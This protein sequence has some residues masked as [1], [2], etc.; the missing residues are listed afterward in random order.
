MSIMEANKM[1]R[2]RCFACSF[3]LLLTP[4]LALAGSI[5]F[6]PGSLIQSPG[7]IF[8]AGV[9]IANP[10]PNGVGDYDL[11]ISFSSAVLSASI[12]NFGTFLGGPINSIQS[13]SIGLGSVEI[14]EVSLL[15]PSSLIALQPATFTLATITFKTLNPGV[16]TLNFNDVV[17]DDANGVALTVSSTPGSVAV[18]SPEPA[19]LGVWGTLI[20][21]LGVLIRRSAR[22]TKN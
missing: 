12:V 2:V 18:V 11:T 16:T 7:D 4:G 19:Y 6:V 8:M 21:G 9:Q 5:G 3:G 20:M 15:S 17:I 22:S 14:A 13:S 1:R 10:G